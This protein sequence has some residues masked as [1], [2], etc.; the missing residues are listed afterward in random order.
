MYPTHIFDQFAGQVRIHSFADILDVGQDGFDAAGSQ[1][2]VC[3]LPHTA[4]HQYLAITNGV[5]HPGVAVLGLPVHAMSVTML[6]VMA[7]LPGKLA[8]IGFRSGFL[9]SHPAI[10]HREDDVILGTTEMG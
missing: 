10:F 6:A 7:V 8:V 5:H 1:A 4:R 3:A 2:V 9:L